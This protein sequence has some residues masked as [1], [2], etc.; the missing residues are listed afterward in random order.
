M[1]LLYVSTFF[2]YI[3]GLLNLFGVNQEYFIKHFVYALIGLGIFFFIRKVDISFFKINS[4]FFYWLFIFLLIITYVIGFEAKGSKRWIDLY[5]FNFQA[6]EF[7][8]VFFIVFLADLFSKRRS[9]LEMLPL[10]VKSIGFFILPT[11]IVFKQPDLST[12]IVFTFIFF[13][14][15]FF[16]NIPKR[17]FLYTF[18]I[19]LLILPVSTFFLQKHQK[20]RIM[21]FLTPHLNQNTTSYNMNQAMISVGSGGFIGKGLGL[22]PQSQLYFLPENHTDFAYSSLVE[23]FGFVGGLAVIGLYVTAAFAFLRKIIGYF[24]QKDEDGRFKFYFTLGVFAFLIFQVFVNIGMNIGILPIA[25][26]TLPLI[27]YGGSSLMTWMIILA[28]LS[29]LDR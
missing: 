6:S 26:I 20:D 15:S 22:G 25:G 8:K 4:K 2:L 28:I 11:F 9:A 3:F 21:G 19:L 13:V 14:I 27:S 10:Y 5:F 7:F 23:Q 1:I 12:A 16:S 17:Y 24:Y 18:L 29:K